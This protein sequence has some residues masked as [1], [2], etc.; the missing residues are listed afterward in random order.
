LLAQPLAPARDRAS[1]DA[2]NLCKKIRTAAT[3]SDMLGCLALPNVPC[4]REDIMK[5]AIVLT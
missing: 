1:R 4:G 2:Y 5:I 3:R